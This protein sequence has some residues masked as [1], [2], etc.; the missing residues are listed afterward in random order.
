MQRGGSKTYLGDGDSSANGVGGNIVL[1]FGKVAFF[2]GFHV[3]V[4]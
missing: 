4:F 1:F 2:V 3:H